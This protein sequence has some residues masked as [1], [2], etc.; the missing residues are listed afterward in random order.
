MS[1]SY[2]RYK[3]RN[4]GTD[5]FHITVTGPGYNLDKDYLA[6]NKGMETLDGWVHKGP[7]FREGGPVTIRSTE[8][9]IQPCRLS[10]PGFDFQKKW[11]QTADYIPNP[12]PNA[13]PMLAPYNES[14]LINMGTKAWAKAKPGKP[15]SDVG[16]FLGE[17]KDLPAMAKN[18]S[19]D[20]MAKRTKDL[21][22]LADSFRSMDKSKLSPR[23]FARI[24]R[25]ESRARRAGRQRLGND[26]LA[27]DFG[28]R[29]FLQDLYGFM[30]IAD[31]T[32][33]AYE[34]LRRDNGRTVR[35]SLQLTNESSNS[36]LS[37][38]GPGYLLPT[39]NAYYILDNP[40]ANMKKE[41]YYTI[42]ER[43]WFRGAFKYFIPDI[44]MPSAKPRLVRKLLG[45]NPSPSL[46]YELTPWSWMA[47][48][49]SS[50][51]AVASNLSDGAAEGLVALYAFIMVERT[52]TEAV[53]VRCPTK[54]WGTI[55]CSYKL[56]RTCKQRYPSRPYGFGVGFDGASANQVATA[57]ALGLSRS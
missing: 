31:R 32:H 35:R 20:D 23:Q 3:E 42:R 41:I 4:L 27:G 11:S 49:F 13:W 15:I 48:W 6:R 46:V 55:S 14:T 17:M 29:P 40:A 1:E 16:V 9:D 50:A 51:G 56:T 19:F 33:K 53:S 12:L 26:Y 28:W 22:D 25:D 54:R 37:F 47:D 57:A 45:M 21:H 10:T 30:D 5:K 8:I 44:G 34:R 24:A 38:T 7:P 18:L 39:E 52:E 43:A 36:S 2:T